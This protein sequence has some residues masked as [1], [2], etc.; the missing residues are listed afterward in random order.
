MSDNL[1]KGW[2]VQSG[3]IAVG[4]A[5]G[6]VRARR[7]AFL[8]AGL[9]LVALC[10]PA[11]AQDAPPAAAAPAGEPQRAPDTF[12]ISAIDVLGATKLPS[13][14]IERLI[15]PYLGPGRSNADVVAAQKALQAAYAAKGYEAVE[16]EIPVQPSDQFA[17]GIVRLQVNEAPL[18]QVQVVDA[19]HHSAET[20]RAQVPSLVEGQPINLAALQRDI[21]AA[22]RFPDRTITPRFKAGAAPGTVDIDLKVEDSAPWHASVELNNDNSPNTDPL[23]ASGTVRYTNLWGQGHTLSVTGSIAPQDPDQ[24]TVISASYSAPLIGTPWSFLLYGYK[25][26]SDVAALGGTNVLGNGYQIGFRATYRLPSEKTF[27]Q[28]SFGPDFKSFKEAIS[29]GE[30]ALQPTHIRYVP[31][32]AEYALSGSDEHETY[33]LSLGVTG[34]LRVIKRRACFE[35]PAS[36]IPGGLSICSLGDGTTGVVADQFRGRAIDANENFFHLNLDMN[37]TRLLPSDVQLALRFAGQLADSPLITNEQFSLGGV[38]NVRGYYVSEAVGDDGFVSSIELRSPSL[39]TLFGPF[40]DELRFFA[41]AD[42]GYARVRA[43]AEGQTDDFRLVGVGGGLRFQIFKL[44]SGEFLVGVPLK[45]GPVTD[46]GDPRYSF[47]VRGE[48]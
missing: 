25:S 30:T 3:T 23:R 38:S 17:Q 15:E 46:K 34:G 13:A 20:A 43:V 8:C 45:A 36:V 22:N 48:F 40:V 31:L 16:V 24:S 4:V 29:L 11:R 26:N 19:K 9:S 33:G 18:G 39:G 32:V 27:Q 44:L 41:F 10:A 2:L 7:A 5:T 28:I 35:Y 12:F 21:G 1:S 47:S 6:A 14:E 37:Y 42:A